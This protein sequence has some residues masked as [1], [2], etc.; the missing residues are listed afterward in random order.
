MK[1]VGQGQRDKANRVR[2]SVSFEKPNVERALV[3]YRK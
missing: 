3:S 2:V 1:I